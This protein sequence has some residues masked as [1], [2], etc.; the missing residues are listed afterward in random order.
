MAAWPRAWKIRLIER[1]NPG[2]DDLY[3][4]LNG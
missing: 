2:W 4:G 3:E 1:D